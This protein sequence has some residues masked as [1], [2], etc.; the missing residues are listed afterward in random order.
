MQLNAS[1][2]KV[3][4]AQD[5]LVSGMRESAVKQLG[6]VTTSP[7]YKQLLKNLILQVSYVPL[8]FQNI[9]AELHMVGTFNDAAA[10]TVSGFASPERT[11]C[12][13]TL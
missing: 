7:S 6:T 10:M 1:R 3:L 8:F 11:I 9:F 2:L 4:Q 5:D 12:Y 13:L